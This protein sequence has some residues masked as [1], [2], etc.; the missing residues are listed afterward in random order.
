VSLGVS[1]GLSRHLYVLR[2]EGGRAKQSLRLADAVAGKGGVGRAL[3]PDDGRR[4]LADEIVSP[5]PPRCLNEGCPHNL[6][7]TWEI[8]AVAEGLGG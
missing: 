4:S 3:P 7:P 2:G 8:F 6:T 5:S 1:A